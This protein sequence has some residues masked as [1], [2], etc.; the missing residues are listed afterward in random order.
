MK[1]LLKETMYSVVIEDK[2]L[3]IEDDN[4]IF[5]YHCSEAIKCGVFLVVTRLLWGR[6]SF[7]ADGPS[8]DASADRPATFSRIGI[9][10]LVSFQN[11]RK[12]S[13]SLSHGPKSGSDRFKAVAETP[14]FCLFI[15]CV[16]LEPVTS[17][18]KTESTPTIENLD[19]FPVWLVT[20]SSWSDLRFV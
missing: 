1:T 6:S 17:P 12:F 9:F 15:T 13:P 16:A 4:I 20:R 7:I 10:L 18:L 2:T 11:P 19:K 14:M 5:E 8:R 3:W